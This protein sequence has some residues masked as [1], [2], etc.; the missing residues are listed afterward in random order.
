MIVLLLCS[1]SCSYFMFNFPLFCQSAL[2]SMHTGQVLISNLYNIY[3]KSLNATLWI[4]YAA[5]LISAFGSV[6]CANAKNCF[7]AKS[8]QSHW[9]R[10]AANSCDS[11]NDRRECTGI[12]RNNGNLRTIRELRAGEEILIAY[13]DENYYGWFSDHVAV[14]N[15]FVIEFC[16]PSSW[17][18][19]EVV[20][21]IIIYTKL[22]MNFPSSTPPTRP[23][24][25]R[26]WWLN[27]RRPQRTLLAHHMNGDRSKTMKITRYPTLDLFGAKPIIG[28]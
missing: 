25:I 5:N 19:S 13:G 17:K 7:D 8:S 27:T 4:I 23:L 9:S 10:F 22:F 28:Y 1:P 12:I 21:K 20:N 26:C 6:W 3:L 14:L 18:F 15:F 24:K 2:V 16:C 11:P